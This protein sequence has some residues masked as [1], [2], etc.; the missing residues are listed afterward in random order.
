MHHLI[1]EGAELSGKSWIM[2]Q[3]YNYLEPR[4]NQNKNTLDGCHWF[5]CDNGVFGTDDSKEVI[6][7]Y[8]KI[9]KA[10]K[11]KNLIIEKFIIADKIYHRMHNDKEI[12][13]SAEEVE[14]EKLNFK[15]IF[16]TFSEDEE[17]IKKR[18]QDRLNIYPH[19]KNILQEP[20]WYI[21]QQQEYKKEIKKSNFPFFVAET[22]VLPD[23]KLVFEILN[24]IGE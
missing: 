4:Y 10:L 24:W 23:E 3:I 18:I 9:F 12:D 6:K 22:N 20:K 15:T 11:E 2:S 14:L 13:Y 19:Y 21:K 8:L 17:I 7:G 1:F 16:I 5:N